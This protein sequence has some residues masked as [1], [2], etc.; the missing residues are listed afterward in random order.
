MSV[1]LPAP[2]SPI[3]A[4]TSPASSVER[5]AVERPR[6][7]ERLA[8]VP[9]FQEHGSR[10]SAARVT[11]APESIPAPSRARSIPNVLDSL[12]Q[13]IPSTCPRYRVTRL[14]AFCWAESDVGPAYSVSE[15][16]VILG[17]SLASVSVNPFS[18]C[19][20]LSEPTAYR[21]KMTFPSP[22][23]Q[24]A[25]PLGR[26]HAAVVV[27]GG[28]VAHHLGRFQRR[29]EDHHRNSL[30]DRRLD[31][32]DER[33]GIE[34]GDHDSVDACGDRILNELDLQHA[35]VFLLRTLPDHFDVPQLA[36]QPRACRHEASSRIHASSPSESRS[37]GISSTA[38]R[39]ARRR[40]CYRPG[41]DESDVATSGSFI[42]SGV[43][44]VSPVEICFSTAASRDA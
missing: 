25:E 14:C 18:R 2:F 44:S 5:D 41:E 37:P 9:H 29:V 30:G 7:S 32:F 17:N 19:S 23:K 40:S 12:G 24:L 28:D 20:V 42:F 3:K 35:I 22:L 38:A 33:P 21:S 4:R 31:R 13:K 39:K 10:L 15:I 36:W 27:V 43:T 1:L 16:N 34:R 8:Y 11:A 26:Q 6:R